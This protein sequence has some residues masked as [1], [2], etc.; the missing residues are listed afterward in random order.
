MYFLVLV[1]ILDNKSCFILTDIS[2]LKN[3][4][5]FIQKYVVY[6][7]FFLPKGY[8]HEKKIT[9]SRE[10]RK[11]LRKVDTAVAF[12]CNSKI[13]KVVNQSRLN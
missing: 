7:K 10:N 1:G 9:P 8:F 4:P 13:F 12:G 3:V 5:L 11:K 6:F 2:P